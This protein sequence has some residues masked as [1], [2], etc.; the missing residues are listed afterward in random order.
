[1]KATTRLTQLTKYVATGV[2]IAMLTACGG[3]GGG[4]SSN[5]DT[6]SILD[7]NSSRAESSAESNE[8]V[9]TTPNNAPVI[10]SA[11]T[12]TVEENQNS[13]ITVVATDA[14]NNVITYSIE[15]G[16]DADRVA[17]NSSTGAVVFIQTPN[18]EVKPNYSFNVGASDN[19]DKTTQEINIT[20]A[21][22]FE[23]SAPVITTGDIS[24]NENQKSAFTITATDIDGDTLIYSLEGGVDDD[25]F[26]INATTG[27][28]TFRTEPDYETKDSYQVSVGADDGHDKTTKDIT[29][30]ILD[31]QGGSRVLQTGQSIRYVNH[32]DGDYLAGEERIFSRTTEIVKDEIT[33]LYW[34]DNTNFSVKNYTE[35]LNYCNGLNWNEYNDWRLPTIEELTMIVDSG[36]STDAIFSEFTNTKSDKNYWSSTKR[37]DGIHYTVDFKT[38]E[39]FI[40]HDTDTI[41]VRCVRK[42]F[43]LSSLPY[44]RFTRV[45]NIISDDETKLQWH[46]PVELKM[47]GTF[48]N[49]YLIKEGL[50]AT[51]GT[52]DE[53]IAGCESLVADGKNDWRLANINELIS[54]SDYSLE[55]ENAFYEEF[56]SVA[57]GG[58]FSSTTSSSDSDKAWTLSYDGTGLGGFVIGLA[59]N[60]YSKTTTANYRCVRTMGD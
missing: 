49:L 10:T 29:V 16:A 55:D 34:K 37:T 22:V 53:A 30:T 1:M 6:S 11:S 24:V 21:D 18:F 31:I 7:S 48:P 2:A 45:G 47:I 46:D 43:T 20:I 39:T 36:S 50:P 5:D 57:T 28:V 12:A 9:D 56:K 17:I 8:T 4:S 3:G 44:N 42:D 54:I 52:F 27:V 59:Q 41:H 35:A 38:G 13:A 32:D 15:G 60:S 14:D 25:S 23:G 19:V 33:R 51:K 26:D 58:Y 40:N